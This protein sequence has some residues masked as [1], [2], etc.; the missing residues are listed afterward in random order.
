MFDEM[1]DIPR[2]YASACSNSVQ[3]VPLHPIIISILFHHYKELK[4]C[5][6]EV[7]QI[8]AKVNS[9]NKNLMKEALRE[10]EHRITA[11]EKGEDYKGECQMTKVGGN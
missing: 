4:E 9:I 10:I 1:W 6:S 11:S 2:L 7:E 8:E 3:L 5:I